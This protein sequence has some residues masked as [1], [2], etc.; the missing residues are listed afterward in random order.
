MVNPVIN[1]IDMKKELSRIYRKLYKFYGPQKWW[2][3]DTP[4]EVVVG[5]IL[6]QN[7]SW[8]NVE[9]AI[10]NLKTARCLS[11]EK[12]L[13]IKH[14][15]L[16]SLI[17]PAGYYNIKAKRIKNFLNF[18]KDNYH[19][20]LNKM[21]RQDTFLLR[22]ELL[23]V[24]G[25][26]QET[27]DSIL[28]YALGKPVFVI[29]AYTKRIFSR[30]KY[31]SESVDYTDAQRFFMD[32]LTPEVKVFNEFHALIVRCAKDFCKKKKQNCCQCPLY[33]KP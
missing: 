28:L 31:L 21:G 26:G 33:E 4:F 30:H 20:C 27:A 8:S 32:D 24:N 23:E 25:I 11:F 2:P 14:N 7:T 3:A 10:A 6:T 16:A 12:L 5:A 13:K 18:L 1:S 29:D 17:K 15:K 22:K 19:G 9:R